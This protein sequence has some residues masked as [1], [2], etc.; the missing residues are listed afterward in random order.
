MGKR[1]TK[2]KNI[3]EG[4]EKQGKENRG[5]ARPMGTGESKICNPTFVHLPRGSR[6][7]PRFISA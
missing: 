2:S 7:T 3:G 6:F 4:L 1:T 5:E